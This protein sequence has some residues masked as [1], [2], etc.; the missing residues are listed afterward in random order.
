MVFEV[1]EGIGG[2]S[3]LGDGVV[4]RWVVRSARCE[5]LNTEHKGNGEV[6]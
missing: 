4:G 6:C 5:A 3:D 1:K 2:E